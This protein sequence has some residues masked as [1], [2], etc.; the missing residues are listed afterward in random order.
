MEMLGGNYVGM[1]NETKA[2]KNCES[3]RFWT[4]FPYPIFRSLSFCSVEFHTFSI[5]NSKRS[6]IPCFFLLFCWFKLFHPQICRHFCLLFSFK[7][8]L[9]NN[10]LLFISEMYLPKLKTTIIKTIKKPKM[11]CNKSKKSNR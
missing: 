7:I 3:P 1:A 4:N 5:A 10:K 11:F 2:L 8:Y 9:Q 6:V